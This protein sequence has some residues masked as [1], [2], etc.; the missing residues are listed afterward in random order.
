MTT[1]FKVG[2]Q[3]SKVTGKYRILGEVRSVFTRSDGAV[4]VVVE[5]RADGDGTFLHIYSEEN[6]AVEWSGG[7]WIEWAG[8]ECPVDEETVVD[9]ILRE[10][11]IDYVKAESLLCLARAGDLRWNHR[12][13]D[14]DIIAYRIHKEQKEAE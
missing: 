12:S 13:D 5:T 1:V 11:G 2:D 7:D 4:R 10:G 3:V 6:L 8:G 9:Y 14:S